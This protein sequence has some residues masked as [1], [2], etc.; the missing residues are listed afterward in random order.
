MMTTNPTPNL[1]NNAPEDLRIN[2]DFSV[3]AV[4]RPDGYIFVPTPMAMNLQA[5]IR[6]KPFRKPTQTCPSLWTA[7]AAMT[8]S[9]QAQAMI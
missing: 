6:L 9:I 8:P 2:D 5:L 4:V 1:E 3:R 7:L